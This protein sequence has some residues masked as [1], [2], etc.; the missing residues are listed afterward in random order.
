MI[1]DHEYI[2][3]KCGLILDSLTMFHKHYAKEHK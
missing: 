3:P 1:L 2:C